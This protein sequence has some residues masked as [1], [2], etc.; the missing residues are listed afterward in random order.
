M[1]EWWRSWHGAPTDNKWLVIARKAGVVPG[2]VSAI[3]WALLDYASQNSNRG[4]IAGFDVE[5]YAEFSGFTEADIEAVIAALR[6]KQVIDADDRLTAW[7]K[8]QPKREDDS[9]QR[10]REH[11][12]RQKALVT[13]VTEPPVTDVTQCNAVKQEVTLDTDTDKKREEKEIPP[14]KPRRSLPHRTPEDQAAVDK[15]R[16][17]MTAYREVLAYPVANEGQENTA[18]KKLATM[19]YD[20]EQIAAC[21]RHL[22]DDPFWKDKHLSLA[23]VAKQIGAY[24]ASSSDNGTGPTGQ[25]TLTVTYPDGTT[26]DTQVV[27]HG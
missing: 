18:A 16:A 6:A 23:S 25:T 15:Q 5:T 3:A 17:I 1:M 7:D 14:Q 19:G 8:R 21:Y 24:R 4:S 9:T 20:P 10:V 11:R 2:I 27:T 22:K 13:D 26:E 12:A